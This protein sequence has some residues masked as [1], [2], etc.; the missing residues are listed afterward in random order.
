MKIKI[1][2]LLAVAALGVACTNSAQSNE[3]S[4]QGWER[5]AGK[6]YRHYDSQMGVACYQSMRTDGSTIRP[7][8]SCVAVAK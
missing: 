2:L 6:L 8:L 3:D 1:T 5:Q 4:W 7:Q